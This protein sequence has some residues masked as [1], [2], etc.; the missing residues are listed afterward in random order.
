MSAVIIPT[1][2][3]GNDDDGAGEGYREPNATLHLEDEAGL[4]VVL[5]PKADQ[6]LSNCPNILFERRKNGWLIFICVDGGDEAGYLQIHDDG[7]A[8]LMRDRFTSP[9]LECPAPGEDGID[10]D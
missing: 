7:R 1:Y 10:L 4:R 3:P 6:P 5:Q 2:Y 9:E 8:C